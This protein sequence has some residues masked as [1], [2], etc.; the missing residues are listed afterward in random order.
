MSNK[1]VVAE[2]REK[3]TSGF[4]FQNYDL[5]WYDFTGITP[6]HAKGLVAKLEIRGYSPLRYTYVR[7]R[8]VSTTAGLIDEKDFAF[9]DYLVASTEGRQDTSLSIVQDGDRIDWYHLRPTDL[10]LLMEPIELY[11]MTWARA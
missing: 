7:V 11:L 4:K 8:I 1:P 3:I 6:L 10:K 2:A 9:S 5:R